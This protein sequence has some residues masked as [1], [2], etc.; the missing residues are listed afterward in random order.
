MRDVTCCIA[1]IAYVV[2]LV[3]VILCVRGDYRAAYTFVVSFAA[4]MIAMLSR[5]FMR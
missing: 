4:V 2:L 5:L 1:I 3:S